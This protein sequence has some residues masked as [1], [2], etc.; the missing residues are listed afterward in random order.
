MPYAKMLGTAA[1]CEPLEFA[2]ILLDVRVP[3][4]SAWAACRPSYG[5][6]HRFFIYFINLL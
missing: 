6:L 1:C 3:L 5:L 4:L 2:R